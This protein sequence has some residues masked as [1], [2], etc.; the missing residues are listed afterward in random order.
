MFISHWREQLQLYSD[1]HRSDADIAR[2]ARRH[3]A[4]WTNTY[5]V[6]VPLPREEVE[7]GAQFFASKGV[8][9]INANGCVPGDPAKPQKG[10]KRKM[11]SAIKKPT[12][13]MQRVSTGSTS[14]MITRSA[15]RRRNTEFLQLPGPTYEELLATIAPSQTPNVS[16]PST[17]SS[18]FTSITSPCSRSGPV[19]HPDRIALVPQTVTR[20]A[21]NPL[22]SVACLPANSPLQS[23]SI[24]DREGSTDKSKMASHT[25]TRSNI[26]TYVHPERSVQVPQASVQSTA[27]SVKSSVLSV[28]PLNAVASTRSC[29]TTARRNLFVHPERIAQVP[30]TTAR[31]A[32]TP[33]NPSALEIAAVNFNAMVNTRSS[34][35]SSAQSSTFIHPERIAQVPHTAAAAA[36]QS[37]ESAERPS[38]SGVAPL[39][40]MAI[41]RIASAR[42]RNAPFVHPERFGQVPQTSTDIDTPDEHAESSLLGAP[43]NLDEPKD[44]AVLI[45][46]VCERVTK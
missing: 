17:T 3:A 45:G 29:S 5:M 20:R 43:P 23:P 18:T 25:S 31:S 40:T 24:G 41:T 22:S 13:K 44:K 4:K 30:R 2:E 21:T 14:R 38:V 19:V 9:L 28:A 33:Q 8:P 39:N 10:K 35:T 36:A 46:S 6:D 15:A 12:A 37:T 1:P 34:S 11:Q 27:T 32:E 26:C 16:P 7:R 42:T